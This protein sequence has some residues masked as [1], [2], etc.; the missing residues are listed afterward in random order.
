MV[1]SKE[2][3][4]KF[5]NK[6]LPNGTYLIPKKIIKQIIKKAIGSTSESDFIVI[7][8]VDTKTYVVKIKDGDTFDTKKSLGEFSS[9]RE[10]AKLFTQHLVKINLSYIVKIRICSFNQQSKKR[11]VE[12][13]K[14]KISIQE[15]WSGDDFCK[16]LGIF[17][18]TIVKQMEANQDAN[19]KFFV[20]ELMKIP[21]IIKHINQFE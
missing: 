14:N 8:I 3:F 4:S 17:Y 12:W 11:I 5:I 19:L 20:D 21:E 15:A 1:M 7:V 16:I 18:T 2:D 6:T 10:F 13:L 9:C